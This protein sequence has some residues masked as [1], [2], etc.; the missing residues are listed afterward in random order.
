MFV[1]TPS[2]LMHHQQSSMSFMLTD[3]TRHFQYAVFSI[4]LVISHVLLWQSWYY[5]NVIYHLSD[6]ERN[7]WTCEIL[8]QPHTF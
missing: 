7:A 6:G 2:R 5:Q 1:Y 3:T 4:Q 8:L